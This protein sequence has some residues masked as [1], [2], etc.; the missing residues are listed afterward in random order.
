MEGCKNMKLWLKVSA[1][2]TPIIVIGV[3][4]DF[5]IEKSKIPFLEIIDEY[6]QETFAALCTIAALGSGILSVIIGSLND[7]KLYGY[8][9]KDILKM[10]PKQFSIKFLIAFPLVLIVPAMFFMSIDYCTAL[11]FL[12]VVV[13]AIIIYSSYIVWKLVSD[14]KYVK[15]IIIKYVFNKSE[16]KEKTTDVCLRII[17]EL[18]SLF[19]NSS[20][21]TQD[22]Y[23]DLLKRAIEAGVKKDILNTPMIEKQLGNIFKS[24]CFNLGFVNAYRKVICFNDWEYDSIFYTDKIVTDYIESIKFCP[25]NKI[26]EY[27]IPSTVNDIIENMD[28]DENSIIRYAFR[29]FHSVFKNSVIDKTTK[30]VLMKEIICNLT[31]L[32]EGKQGAIRGKVLLYICKHCVFENE[33]EETRKNVFLLIINMLHE[34]N[35]FNKDVCYISVVSQMFRALYFYS[36]YEKSTLSEKYRQSLFELFSYRN[37]DNCGYS[38]NIANLIY[39]NSDEIVKWLCDDAVKFDERISMFDYFPYAM[40]C[41]NIIWSRRNLLEFAFELYAILGYGLTRI[42]PAEGFLLPENNDVKT[43]VMICETIVNMFDVDEEITFN[44]HISKDI[45]T[46]QKT[47]GKSRIL[48]QHFIKYN[49]EYFNDELAKLRISDDQNSIEETQCR[50]ENLVDIINSHLK[51]ESVFKRNKNLS[52]KNAISVTTKPYLKHTSLIDVNNAA[53]Y[54]VE[55][56]HQIINEFIHQRLRTVKIDFGI[57]GTKTL[58]KELRKSE[59][60]Y[61]NYEYINDYAISKET[62]EKEEF[63]SLSALIKEIPFDNSNIIRDNVFLKSC[64]IEYNYEIINY[65]LVVPTD[66]DCDE[67]INDH[68]IADGRYRIDGVIYDYKKAVDY[69]KEKYRVEKSSFKLITNITKNSGFK[70]M[71]IH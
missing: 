6:S 44:K 23:I 18:D 40:F 4:I 48:P 45:Q 58:L 69:L 43:K 38:V 27:N 36:E 65:D 16:D 35:Q 29:Y 66:A 30:N 60:K 71:F 2:T 7:H 32:R 56:I 26:Y 70:I 22:D 52:L 12:M 25:A 53:T 51:K 24:A 62:R 3:I 67:F 46:L 47:L 20:E 50:I 8:S 64:T 59:Y 41:K 68:K 28:I 10:A 54:K 11:T 31:L 63:S 55:E 5:L 13:V 42:F 39:R 15:N 37:N 19:E 17:G 57:N 34:N 14:D 33:I 49:L 9:L 61:R 21:K 1:V